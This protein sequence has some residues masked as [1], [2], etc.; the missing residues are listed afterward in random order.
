MVTNA[1]SLSTKGELEILRDDFN[2]GFNQVFAKVSTPAELSECLE[3][4]QAW[5]SVEMAHR[6][7]GHRLTYQ[8]IA[9]AVALAEAVQSS[10]ALRIA[11]DKECEARGIEPL[12]KAANP[13]TT[14][15]G[16][17]FG[18]WVKTEKDGSTS[19]SWIRNKTWLNLGGA[20]RYLVESK[21]RP[22]DVVDHIMN[23]VEK[24][25]NGAEKTKLEAL[26]IRDRKKHPAKSPSG[27]TSFGNDENRRKVTTWKPV[28]TATVDP[29]VLKPNSEN[30]TL[31]VARVDPVNGNVE[32]LYDANLDHETIMKGVREGLKLG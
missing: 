22:E 18:H 15:L 1:I 29:K 19:N 28:A 23:A 8:A 5:S 10:S 32:V 24:D 27:K 26:K 7:R 9:F 6:G 13:F 17:T 4:G 14:Y 20:L 31:M 21:I 11:F 30:L 12:D 3:R 2:Q 16:A 25:A